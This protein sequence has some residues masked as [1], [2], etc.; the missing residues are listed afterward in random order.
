MGTDKAQPGASRSRPS[1]NYYKLL[2]SH[3][4]MCLDSEESS[5]LM[6]GLE[7]GARCQN[8]FLFCPGTQYSIKECTSDKIW[9]W[10][11]DNLNRL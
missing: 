11:R 10:I 7:D 4:E 6:S 9:N 1:G 5:N 2:S 8:D 3:G